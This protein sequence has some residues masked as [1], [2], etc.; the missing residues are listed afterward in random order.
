MVRPDPAPEAGPNRLTPPNPGGRGD[1]SPD[2]GF[3]RLSDEEINEFGP[4]T[5]GELYE[6]FEGDDEADRMRRRLG[7]DAS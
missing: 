7:G 6:R 2:D 3:E 5:L 1:W 4:M